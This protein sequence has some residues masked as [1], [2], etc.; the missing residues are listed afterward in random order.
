M[1]DSNRIVPMRLYANWESDRASSSAVQRVFSMS[2]NRLV[3]FSINEPLTSLV[4]TVKLQGYKRTLRSNDFH[5]PSGNQADVDLNISFTVQYPHF[6]KRKTNLLQILLQR[7]KKYKTRPIPGFKT[8]AVG[9]VNLTEVLQ[10]GCVREIQLWSPEDAEKEDFAQNVKAIGC[11]FVSNCCTQAVDT[12]HETIFRRVA[13]GTDAK[14]ADLLLSDENDDDIDSS[15]DDAD[16][17]V[18]QQGLT[19]RYNTVISSL[20]KH[21]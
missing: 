14:Q 19:A 7:R 20:E 4:I 16:S 21:V 10:Y 12:D 5:V 18:D 8:L 3:I 1:V 11:L 13:N 6:L 2:L 17:D 9:C 15:N